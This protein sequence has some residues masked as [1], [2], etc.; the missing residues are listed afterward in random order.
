MS[1]VV[2]RGAGSVKLFDISIIIKTLGG[3]VGA[4]TSTH[5]CCSV[6]VEWS[7][8]LP[9]GGST[10]PIPLQSSR[11][12]YHVLPYVFTYCML[13][14]VLKIL[15]FCKKLS[16]KLVEKK[17]LHYASSELDN[18]HMYWTN[19]TK[20][21]RFFHNTF[22]TNIIHILHN[23]NLSEKFSSMEWILRCRQK[24]TLRRVFA[25]GSLV[26]FPT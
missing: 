7:S 1:T 17:N 20:F 22:R 13:T 2:I 21:V 4:C 11:L 3:G 10:L 12:G 14:A 6:Y 23:L 15:E 18:I 19:H 25:S 26:L 16:K 5:L 9:E 8:W 24:R